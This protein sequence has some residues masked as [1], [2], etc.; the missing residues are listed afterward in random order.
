MQS[1]YSKDFNDQ[2][3]AEL[4]SKKLH[5]LLKKV[6]IDADAPQANQLIGNVT[7]NHAFR[8]AAKTLSHYLYLHSV[9]LRGI[10]LSPRKSKEKRLHVGR[11]NLCVGVA[12]L[13]AIIRWLT[14]EKEN[15]ATIKS[16]FAQAKKIDQVS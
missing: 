3:M 9:E 14:N 2:F 11:K 7:A 16:V 12:Y 15:Y 1:S 6:G 5:P 13:K 4:V 10:L 8:T